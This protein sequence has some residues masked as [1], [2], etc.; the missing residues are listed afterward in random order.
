MAVYDKNDALKIYCIAILRVCNLG[1]KDY[2]LKGAYEDSFL[3]EL[4]PDV[5]ISKNT[6]SK[7]WNNLGKAYSRICLYMKLR[8]AAV[9]KGHH[10]IIDG[11]LKSNESTVNSLSD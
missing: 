3:S 1:I 10:I 2:E 11:T 8:A 6:V 4:Y 5:A 9:E 7:F